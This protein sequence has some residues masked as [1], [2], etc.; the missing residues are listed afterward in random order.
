MTT[1]NFRKVPKGNSSSTRNISQGTALILP[2]P[3]QFIADYLPKNDHGHSFPHAF[4]LSLTSNYL[5]R[6]AVDDHRTL[7]R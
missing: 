6:S 2:P 7:G 1:L 5:T 4:C 3:A